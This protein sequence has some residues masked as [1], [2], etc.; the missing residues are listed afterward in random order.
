MV[1][2]SVSSITFQPEGIPD[3]PVGN[4][5]IEGAFTNVPVDETLLTQFAKHFVAEI[6]VASI[7][8]LLSFLQP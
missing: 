1:R 3:V 2:Y 6:L 5:F 8:I 7:V 4:D